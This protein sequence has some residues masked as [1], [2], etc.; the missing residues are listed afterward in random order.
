MSAD[1]ILDRFSCAAGDHDWVP[2]T[3]EPLGVRPKDRCTRCFATDAPPHDADCAC[4]GMHVADVEV[5]ETVC[6]NCQALFVWAEDGILT[7]IVPP[8]SDI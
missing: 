3:D 1:T 7:V 6:P 2:V 4:C 5:G 8:E